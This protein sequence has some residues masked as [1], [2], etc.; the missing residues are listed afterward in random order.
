MGVGFDPYV[1]ILHKDR[2]GRLSLALDLLEEF[3]PSWPDRFVLTLINRR[4]VQACDFITESSG[5]VRL[6]DDARKGVLAAY[7]ERRQ[8]EVI[9]PY[10]QEQV[11][12]GLLPH[13]QAMLPA[14]HFRG[15][16][17]FYTPYLVK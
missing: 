7:Q 12:M 14:R 15:D 1:G 10:L 2:P 9:H 5:A 16:T 11:P 4:Q 6:T 8:V 3:R 13:G 17:E